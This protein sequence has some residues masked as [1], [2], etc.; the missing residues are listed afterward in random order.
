MR[1]LFTEH[2]HQ[3]I[4]LNLLIHSFNPGKD[5]MI[6]KT[7]YIHWVFGSILFSLILQGC[8]AS[9]HYKIPTNPNVLSERGYTYAIYN[10][11]H[12]LMTHP[13]KDLLVQFEHRKLKCQLNQARGKLQRVILESSV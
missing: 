9:Q 11:E 1:L 5:I 12:R 8:L 13:L 2:I 6:P 3:Y 7:P 4:L 10:K